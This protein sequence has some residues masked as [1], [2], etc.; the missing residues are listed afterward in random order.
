[1][2]EVSVVVCTRH[3]PEALRKALAGL[4]G[5]TL[6]RNRYEIVVVDNG[7]GSEALARDAGA[8]VVVCEHRPGVG[9]ARNAGWRAASATLVGYLD[10]DGLPAADWLEQALRLYGENGRKLLAFGGPVLPVWDRP[11]P[12]W[13]REEWEA[14]SWGEVARSLEPGEALSGSNCFFSRRVLESL[15][16][17]DARLGM[18]AGRVGVGEETDLF[19]RLWQAHPGGP[20]A[21]SP[22]VVVSHPVTAHKLTVRYQLR[23]AAAY[24]DYLVISRGPPAQRRQLRTAAENAVDLLKLLWRAATRLRRPLRTWAV[25]ELRE[26]AIRTGIIRTALRTR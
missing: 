22:A 2:P 18:A 21:Y 11:R 17:F 4:A 1:M 8:D 15:G 6:A 3:R 10:D 5:Q 24:G 20:L 14:R 12:S 16:G 26:P 7:G 13:F 19:V 23:R 9:H 25:D